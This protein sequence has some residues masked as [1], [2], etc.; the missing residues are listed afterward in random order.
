MICRSYLSTAGLLCL[1]SLS[2][3]STASP[4]QEQ[5]GGE[6]QFSQLDI[7]GF[8]EIRDIFDQVR[9]D[10][11]NMAVFAQDGESKYRTPFRLVSFLVSDQG[12]ANKAR[13]LYNDQQA[14]VR[15]ASAVGITKQETASLSAKDPAALLFIAV[16]PDNSFKILKVLA[17]PIDA[18]GKRIGKF[19][20][21]F[22][23]ELDQL[24]WKNFERISIGCTAGDNSVGVAI[25]YTVR[26]SYVAAQ[27]DIYSKVYLMETDFS[28]KVT[29]SAAE[30][31]LPNGGKMRELAVAEPGY[32]G[33]TWVVPVS[34]LAYKLS[35]SPPPAQELRR[36]GNSLLMISAKPSGKSYKKKCKTLESDKQT[37]KELS[38]RDLQFL[39]EPATSESPP[40]ATKYFFHRHLVFT[41]ESEQETDPLD[42]HSTL[43]LTKMKKNGKAKGGIKE[44]QRTRWSPDIKLGEDDIFRKT[45][46]QATNIIPLENGAFALCV[47]H[48]VEI[49]RGSCP[50]G[51]EDMEK[52][53]HFAVLAFFPSYDK[54][55][56]YAGNPNINF[57]T[58]K[59]LLN[60]EI[61]YGKAKALMAGYSKDAIGAATRLYSAPL[62][63][64]WDF[65]GKTPK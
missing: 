56:E 63:D 27:P 40:A 39:P 15:D 14:V 64:I 24:R 9:V 10:A 31:T 16:D 44:L 54:V 42:F 57:E 43:N 50:P 21:I 18:K 58:Y 32:F 52:E 23:K 53:N 13:V 20:V 2:I 19:K 28:G 62:G 11:D 60:A 49:V 3:V 37:E 65:Y 12:K 4:A 51:C 5:N 6:I 46:E 38:Y 47:C 25:G 33:A 1:A 45:I 7:K 35:A 34:S 17:A 8:L 48:S 61:G 55:K 59:A 22:R 41:T 26:T 29:R 30:M 36:T